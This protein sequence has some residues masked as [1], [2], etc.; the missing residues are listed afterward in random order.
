MAKHATIAGSFPKH[1]FWDLDP[2]KLQAERDKEIIIPRAL[3]FSNHDSFEQDI[4]RLE[5]FY[6]PQQ[7]LEVLVATKELIS[8]EVRDMV[9][10][11]YHAPKF[12]K[13]APSF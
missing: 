6:S 13:P 10:S 11:R 8:N 3:Y 4:L 12:R 1:L 2:G 7:I 9:A 5:N